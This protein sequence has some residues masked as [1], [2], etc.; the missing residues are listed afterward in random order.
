MGRSLTQTEVSALEGIDPDFWTRELEI[1]ERRDKRS[2]LALI[3]DP[4]PNWS[5]FDLVDAVYVPEHA[6]DQARAIVGDKSG[7]PGRMR[8]ELPRPLSGF[9]AWPAI[10]S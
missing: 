8:R 5:F 9:I 4:I 6:I 10:K 1:D 2:S 7:D 3:Y